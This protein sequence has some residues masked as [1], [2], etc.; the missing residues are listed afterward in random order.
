MLRSALAFPLALLV[1][2]LGSARFATAQ[3]HVFIPVRA[4]D[5]QGRP[6]RLEAFIYRPTGEGR[7]PTLVL[8]HG[9][10]AGAPQTSLPARDLASYFVSR[11][12]AVLVPMRR[13]RGQSSGVSREYE[14]RHCDPSAWEPGLRDAME[15]LSASLDYAGAVAGLDTSRIVLAGVSRG[16]FLSVAYTAE[17]KYRS[18]VIGVVNFVGTWTAQREDHCPR[19]FNALAF[20]KFGGETRV[21]MLWLYGDADP[22]NATADIRSYATR[23]RRAG[24]DAAFV[25]F[26]NVPGN[27]HAVSDTPRLWKKS[28]DAFLRRLQTAASGSRRMPSNER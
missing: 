15:D 12:F 17:G 20:A 21:P 2:A 10:A 5:S 11:G 24:G 4:R 8:S 27:G 9:S 13:G 6:I 16:G 1:G 3:D 18:A 28:V 7:F 25:L 22:F 14:D 26:E 23:F 19:D